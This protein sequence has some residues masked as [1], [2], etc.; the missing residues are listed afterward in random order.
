M[1]DLQFHWWYVPI[2]LVLAFILFGRSKG[3]V[4]RQRY[5]ARLDALD[6]RF[7][8]CRWEAEYKQF[9]EGSPD[10]IEIE[11]ENLALEPGEKLE[12]RLNGALLAEVEVDRSREAEFDHWSD[13]DVSFPRITDGDELVIRYRGVDVM[14]GTFRKR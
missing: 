7:E 13:E 8:Q 10:H 6:P 4:V 5:E 11:L 1:E 12:L 2:A 14:R 9:K 3:G